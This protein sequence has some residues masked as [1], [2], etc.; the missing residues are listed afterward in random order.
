[1]GLVVLIKTM[2][3]SLDAF[4]GKYYFNNDHS[5]NFVAAERFNSTDEQAK[6]LN[7]F[8][9]IDDPKPRHDLPALKIMMRRPN[10]DALFVHD[11]LYNIEITEAAD[12]R[13]IMNCWT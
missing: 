12:G 1:M 4:C 13:K 3:A 7:L 6:M 8:H 5:M 10:S 2:A 11:T 9:D